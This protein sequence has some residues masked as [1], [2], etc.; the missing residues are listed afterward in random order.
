MI[1][2]EVV[3]AVSKGLAVGD[4]GDAQ[5]EVGVGELGKIGRRDVRFH[6]VPSIVVNFEGSVCFTA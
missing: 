6:E 1:F 3:V 5:T 2:M 4:V